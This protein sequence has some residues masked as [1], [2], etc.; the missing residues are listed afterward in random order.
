MPMNESAQLA[1]TLLGRWGGFTNLSAMQQDFRTVETAAGRVQNALNFG[2]G[3][4]VR[5]GPAGF[6]GI[7][8]QD[9][10]QVDMAQR[11]AAAVRGAMS[12]P[13]PFGGGLPFG[14]SP[15]VAAAAGLAVGVGG[16]V[17][18]GDQAKQYETMTQQTAAATNMNTAALKAY[19][20]ELLQFHQEIPGKIQDLNQVFARAFWMGFGGP[21]GTITPS[22]SGFARAVMMSSLPTGA[23]PDLVAAGL[24]HIINSFDMPRTAAGSMYAMDLLHSTMSLGAMS[25]VGQV[26]QYFPR[27]AAMASSSGDPNALISSL[28]LFATLT[29]NGVPLSQASTGE[30]SVWQELLH[31]SKQAETLLS[32]LYYDPAN[33]AQKRLYADISPWGAKNVGLAGVLSDLAAAHL[34]PQQ[35]LTI[36]PGTR[37]A[38]AL[39]PALNNMNSFNAD[40]NYLNTQAPG[41]TQQ[42]YAEWLKTTNAQQLLWEQHLKDTGIVLGG[43]FNEAM[44][45]AN[46]DFSVTSGWLSRLV[47]DHADLAQGLE[48]FVLEHIPVVAAY[49][50]MKLGIQTVSD[51]MHGKF[52][53]AFQDGATFIQNILPFLDPLPGLAKALQYGVDH[54][55][56]TPIKN[57]VH[58]IEDPITGAVAKAYDLGISFMQQLGNGMK[59]QKDWL[60]STVYNAFHSGPLG[61]IFDRLGWNHGSPVS[62]GSAPSGY[63]NNANMIM[64]AVG[65][66]S[67]IAPGSAFGNFGGVTARNTSAPTNYLP[68]GT[69]SIYDIDYSGKQ[70]G[71]YLPGGAG[72]QYTYLGQVYKP[73]MGTLVWFRTPNGGEIGFNHLEKGT[74]FG[75]KS[76]HAGQAISGGAFVGTSGE[77]T[78]SQYG[79]GWHLCV[80]T[81]ASGRTFL[82]YLTEQQQ[83]QAKN[84]GNQVSYAGAPMPGPQSVTA[85][86]VK[87]HLTPWEQK[88][89]ST[90]AKLASHYDVPVAEVLAVLNMESSG[91]MNPAAGVN[92]MQVTSAAWKQLGYS[93]GPSNAYQSLD[94]GIHYLAYMMSRSGGNVYNALMNYNGSGNKVAYANSAYGQYQQLNALLSGAGMNNSASKGAG[95]GIGK[96]SGNGLPDTPSGW[97]DWWQQQEAAPQAQL[98]A[99]LA[100]FGAN[101]PSQLR[102]PTA[103]AAAAVLEQRIAF[104]QYMSNRGQ[105]NAITG[106]S[107]ATRSGLMTKAWNQ[108]MGVWRHPLA[109]VGKTQ[110]QTL[111]DRR[112]QENDQ[113]GTINWEW[114]GVNPMNLP[115]TGN[116]GLNQSQ[117]LAD[118]KR[119]DELW[120][121]MKDQQAKILLLQGKMTEQQYQTLL[122][123]TKI[124]VSTKEQADLAKLHG[125]GAAS[126]VTPVHIIGRCAAEAHANVHREKTAH[127][128]GRIAEHADVIAKHTPQM[129]AALKVIAAEVRKHTTLLRQM[130]KPR[131]GGPPILGP[132]AQGQDALA[133]L[134]W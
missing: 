78:S 11:N 18:L 37:G 112:A 134:G 7:P 93:G 61:W 100:V 4:G 10:R 42:A 54:L 29:K 68:G 64:A 59:S 71:V 97:S 17:Y 99:I 108:F 131:F 107:A 62:S 111:N 118:M 73:G 41:K 23:S 60:G 40:V 101:D 123:A 82:A 106:I 69:G 103:H 39:L 77:P 133:G 109:G 15:A 91:G 43:P 14:L 65:G 13:G 87:K 127:N 95:S 16:A 20:Q 8:S 84:N 124:A 57:A 74:V 22:T 46:A 1:I 31:P 132:R 24:G 104:D 89:L 85:A 32:Q 53:K 115:L 102:D 66:S 92:V 110:I 81:D 105:I 96:G 52:I 80:V 2:G 83:Q 28:A 3:G 70:Q 48:K 30:A 117:W 19:R 121:Q 56:P 129:A 67:Y 98:N 130:T 35:L 76:M 88:N 38:R 122:Q 126:R 44:R 47:T 25:N 63:S 86:S 21:N 119:R 5:G 27:I 45:T 49:N 36:F 114:S 120:G 58:A 51:L 72:D 26:A 50:D 12:A 116:H 9:L 125:G 128:A 79:V 33:A 75:G 6:G 55:L 90:I 94:E 34:D 113:I